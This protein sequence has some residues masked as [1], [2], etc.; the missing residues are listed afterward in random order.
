MRAAPLASR[1]GDDRSVY[2][3]ILRTS[4]QLI[5][6]LARRPS[7]SIVHLKQATEADPAIAL[8]LFTHVNSMLKRAGR[9][10]VTDISRSLL[11]RGIQDFIADVGNS[12][13]LEEVVDPHLCGPMIRMLAS[14]H[15]A[16]RQGYALGR[17]VGG[18]NCDEILATSLTTQML[19]Y[20]DALNQH[21]GTPPSSNE[22][23]W[24]L[25]GSATDPATSPIFRTC[26]D[27]ACEYASATDEGWDETI[28]DTIFSR[29][30][31]LTGREPAKIAS[32][33]LHTT[34][35]AARMGAQ[36]GSY[37]PIPHLMALGLPRKLDCEQHVPVRQEQAP[38]AKQPSAGPQ[39]VPM[40]TTK[41][42]VPA[43]VEIPNLDVVLK[44][45]AAAAN[46]GQPVAKLLPYILQ[47]TC[48]QVN[49]RLAVL[50]VYDKPKGTLSARLHRG[51]RLPK[52]ATEY[53]INAS[54]NPLLQP[55]LETPSMVRWQPKDGSKGLQGLPLKLLGNEEGLFY[56][57]HVAGKAFGILL[58]CR[59]KDAQ[60][61]TALQ[62]A[63]FK[64]LGQATTDTL[65]AC[66][67]N[68][69]KRNS[70]I[71]AA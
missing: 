67:N 38:A 40:P 61:I 43:A 19:P 63:N 57:V 50:L 8:N 52:A 69:L 71:P 53:A 42:S 47:A 18:V 65:V 29:I 15:H 55:L 2:T 51:L 31:E 64:R 49:V 9:A 23:R 33:M 3:P 7:T 68:P 36:F 26:V 48:D 16:S 44:R 30:G 1:V 41:T 46:Q 20:L 62:L 56:S 25:P 60:P 59:P 34:I 24:L 27:L 12:T 37:A 39:P 5:E 58:A 22:I 17:L 6:D 54:S 21:Q 10:P 45:L 14:A 32:A 4:K 35:D 66:R 70:H 11:F 13:V 28:L